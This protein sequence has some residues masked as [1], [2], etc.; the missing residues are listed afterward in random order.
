MKSMKA[1][2]KKYFVI[3]IPC[4]TNGCV[5]EQ[6]LRCCSGWEAGSCCDNRD[7]IGCNS[8][9]FLWLYAFDNKHKKRGHGIWATT[10]LGHLLICI[11]FNVKVPVGGGAGGKQFHS[12][13]PSFWL[14]LWFRQGSGVIFCPGSTLRL[15]E[16]QAY[17]LASR[18]WPCQVCVCKKIGSRSTLA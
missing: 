15:D 14:G 1:L 2:N 16:G 10:K 9:L 11:L 4:S 12:P 5:W 7:W 17:F 3:K 18:P 6:L 13:S 8:E